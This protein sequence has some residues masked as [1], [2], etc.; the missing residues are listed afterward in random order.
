MS[1]GVLAA[2]TF[3]L[4]PWL[5]SWLDAIVLWTS[6]AGVMCAL[7]SPTFDNVVVSISLSSKYSPKALKYVSS[8]PPPLSHLKLPWFAPS[9][10]L[11][12]APSQET[13]TRK[14][15]HLASET[16]AHDTRKLLKE[17]T[18][19]LLTTVSERMRSCGLQN[20]FESVAATSRWQK[21]LSRTT[22]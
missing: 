20:L 5:L 2:A 21:S 7:A 1:T 15:D 11:D 22:C 10:Y 17:L 4:R 12:S 8:N 14:L 13:L 3:Y 16:D 19:R 18:T 6:T 9:F